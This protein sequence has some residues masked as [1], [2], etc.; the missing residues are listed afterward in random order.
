MDRITVEEQARIIER[1]KSRAG[2]TGRNYIPANSGATR[3]AS[4]RALLKAL[5]ELTRDEATRE[6]SPS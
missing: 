4:K 3:T 2:V 6:R 1:W 5:A